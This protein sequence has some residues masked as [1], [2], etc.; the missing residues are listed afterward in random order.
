[1]EG[2][3]PALA[4]IRKGVE[5]LK[6]ALPRLLARL[7]VLEGAQGEGAKAVRA[8]EHADPERRVLAQALLERPDALGQQLGPGRALLRR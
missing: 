1:M 3:D 5:V 2:L 4:E 7:H 8:L 6:V